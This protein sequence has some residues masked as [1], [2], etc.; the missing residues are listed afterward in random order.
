MTLNLKEGGGTRHMD[1]MSLTAIRSLV[2]AELGRGFRTDL[3]PSEYVFLRFER[4]DDGGD[5]ESAG[6]A[7]GA[8]GAEGRYVMINVASEGGILCRGFMFPPDG[9]RAGL[10]ITRQLPPTGAVAGSGKAA[11]QELLQVCRASTL[12][13][14]IC[15]T[16]SPPPHTHTHTYTNTRARA[17]T[18]THT[19]PLSRTHLLMCELA[20]PI[21]AGE[22]GQATR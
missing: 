16:K 2:D 14:I 6:G 1:T 20:L 15:P 8:G 3:H 18:R 5:D 12:C 7:G 10:F 13:T 19:L 22:H 11:S 4:F 9:V 21:H 17:Q